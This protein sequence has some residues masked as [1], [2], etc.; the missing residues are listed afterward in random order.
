MV[1]QLQ[2]IVQNLSSQS[3]YFY[4]FQQQAGFGNSG[5]TPTILSTSLECAQLAPSS[6]GTQLDIAFDTQIYAGALNT[7]VS[8]AMTAFNARIS[9]V[10]TLAVTSQASAA[11]PIELMPAPSNGTANNCSTLMINP[12]GLSTPQNLS[13]LA[14]GSFGVQI[15]PY[16]AKPTPELFCGCAVINQNGIITLSSFIAPA[17][18]ALF[19]CS[20][21]PIYYVKIGSYPVGETI[22]YDTSQAAECDFSTGYQVITV[23]Y[24]PNGTFTTSGS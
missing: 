9:F 24:N 11:Q 23:T 21:R 13:T 1:A 20:P 15:P 3:Q 19:T 5:I 2:I 17:P 16:T 22:I 10:S 12:L 14:T 8:A 6:F 18:N 4:V 7:N